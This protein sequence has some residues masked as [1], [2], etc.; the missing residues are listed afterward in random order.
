MHRLLI[1]QLEQHFGSADALPAAMRPFVE[2]VSAAYVKADA[3]FE[4]LSHSLEEISGELIQRNAALREE[5]DEQ[6]ALARRLEEAHNQLL[7]SEKMSSIGQLAAG[8][9]HEINNPVGYIGSNLNALEGYLDDLLGLVDRYE[10]AEAD[11][12]PA[13]R[14]ELAAQRE[15]IELPYV[16]TEL[17]ALIGES[18]EGVAR[19]RKIV[20]D[21]KDFSHADSGEFAWAN[22]HEG[23]ESTLNIVTN[24]IKYRAD[25]KREYGDIPRVECLPSQM[26]Q[27]FMNLLVN[28]A[29]SIP[30]GRRGTIT[31]RTRCDEAG[32]ADGVVIEIADDGCGIPPDHLKRIFDPFFT[33]K[34]VGKGTGLGLSL[35]YGIVQKHHGRI[36]VDSEVGRGSV[37]RVFLPVRQ[38]V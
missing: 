1:Q 20:K 36:E 11:L 34:P 33:T 37:F 24:E 21:L 6:R 23:L 30:D 19:V 31:V 9:A 25:V 22:L 35:S 38:S 15:R 3:D 5:R 18:Q 29:H 16:K 8:V 32:G 13:T 4:L 26:N 7:Q 14:A 2:A 12:P 10:Q 17:R 27:V 28:A